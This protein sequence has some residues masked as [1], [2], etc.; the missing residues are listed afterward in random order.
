MT[1]V[2]I[3]FRVADFDAWK[4]GYE[5]AI[6]GPLGG[7]LRSHRIWRGQDDRHLVLVEETYDSR[8]KAQ[9]ALDHPATRE[10]M[11]ADGIDLSSLRVDYADEVI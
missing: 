1:T 6:G 3:R 11:E 8:A 7:D 5:R 2:F 10:A 4:E 9:E